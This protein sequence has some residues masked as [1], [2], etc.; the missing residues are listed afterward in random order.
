M[1]GFMCLPTKS[2]GVEMEYLSELILIQD[3]PCMVYNTYMWHL[4]AFM[5]NVGKYSIHGAPAQL[6]IERV[7]RGE[8]QKEQLRC[9]R[10]T[11][12]NF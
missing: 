12:G 9:L 3:V 10:Q 7:H 5:V 1:A 8:G 2:I 11:L 6:K 4:Y